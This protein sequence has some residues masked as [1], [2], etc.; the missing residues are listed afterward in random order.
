MSAVLEA[1]EKQQM[2]QD[3]PDFRAGDT[4]KV[5]VKVVEGEKTR[6]QIFKGIVIAMHRGRNR[7][8]FTVRKIS[9]SIGVERIFPIHSPHLERIEIVKRGKVRRARL[10]YLRDLKGKAARVKDRR[11]AAPTP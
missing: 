11:A 2:R 7:S 6:V 3:I 4:V 8:T 5:H 10:Y 1:I 9:A